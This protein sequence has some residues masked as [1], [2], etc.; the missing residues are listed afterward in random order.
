MTTM[1]VFRRH[2]R[3]PHESAKQAD[4]NRRG[5]L[6]PLE[7]EVIRG[8]GTE[9]AFTGEY[10]DCHEQGVYRCRDCGAELFRSEVKFDSGTGWPSFTRPA[11]PENINTATDTSQSMVR[12]E[13]TCRQCGAHLGH[14]FDD[15]PGPSGLRYCINSVALELDR[16]T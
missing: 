8:A 11:V 5:E 9:R 1:R 10:W 15:G 6:T 2:S 16:E 7:Y 13:V 4:G 12:T 3:I 14:V